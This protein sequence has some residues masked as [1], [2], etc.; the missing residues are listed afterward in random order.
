MRAQRRG[1]TLVELVLVLLLLALLLAVAAP[2]LSLLRERMATLQAFHA[3]TAGL[4]QARMAA[5]ALGRPVTLCP[6]ADGR[7]CRGDLVWDAGWL[8]YVDA[9]RSPQPAKDEDV[10]WTEALAPGPVAIR[11]T[12]GRHR[13]RYQPTG[14]SGGNNASLRLCSRKRAV[15][16]GS[17]VVNIA[18]R[19]RHARVSRVDPP[20]CPFLP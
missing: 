5:V 2:S 8:V 9:T 18:G 17:V 14:M 6:S 20:P 16:L 4:A 1:F 10:L 19:V 3:L 15:H 11:A 7:S 12:P 13:V